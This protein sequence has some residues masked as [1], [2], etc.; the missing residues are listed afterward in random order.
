MYVLILNSTNVVANSNNTKFIYQFPSAVKFEEGSQIAVSSINMFYSWF[1]I[2]GNL[3]NNNTF[4]Y[5]WFDA[6]GALT[7]TVKVVIPNGNYSIATLNDYIQSVLVT[8]GHYIVQTSTGKFVYHIEMLTNPTYYAVQL[9]VYYMMT[10][11][12]ATASGYTKGSN[13]WIFPATNLCPQVII[14]STNTFKSLIGFNSGNYPSTSASTSQSFLS[15]VT[16]T[17]S[18][19]SS[20]VMTCS[21]CEQK[22]SLPDN[23]LFCFTSGNTSFGDMINIQ[24]S[25]LSFVNIRSGTY[26]QVQI[27]LTDQNYGMMNINDPQL[28][29]MLT[30]RTLE[31][32]GSFTN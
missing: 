23:V 17:L 20:V 26:N 3:Y 30:I 1:N 9:N 5:V 32:D 19:V 28:V 4:S 11:A 15:A 18:P 2:N 16:P 14:P 25:A 6:T 10:Q 22:Y 13:T 29:I 8:N 12:T 31:D 24:Q 21:L 7:V 27:S